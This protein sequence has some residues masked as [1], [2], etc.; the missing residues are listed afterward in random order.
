M[1]RLVR[2]IAAIVLEIAAYPASLA[3]LLALVA[4]EDFERGRVRVDE[5]VFVFF[6]QRVGGVGMKRSAV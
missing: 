2:L 6:V 1:E 5:S 4:C 3:E